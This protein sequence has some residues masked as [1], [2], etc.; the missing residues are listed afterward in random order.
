MRTKIRLHRQKQQTKP[1][2]NTLLQ[3][4]TPD[5]A[6]FVPDVLL[7]PITA[8]C[9]GL[10]AKNGWECLHG[11]RQHVCV[12]F[13]VMSI[14]GVCLAATSG[15]LLQMFC[16]IYFPSPP[17]TNVFLEFKLFQRRL[18]KLTKC[19]LRSRKVLYNTLFE[20]NNPR[21]PGINQAN[22]TK[23]WIFLFPIN[24]HFLRGLNMFFSFLG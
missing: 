6:L 22:R 13:L 5:W 10:Q 19:C 21:K 4:C 18:I 16:F 8:E 20:D 12:W 14:S 24:N 11:A 15:T 9:S 2:T 23:T 7:D 3:H 1:K 17:D